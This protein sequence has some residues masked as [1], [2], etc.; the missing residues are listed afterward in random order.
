MKTTQ[1]MLAVAVACLPGC[2]TVD[3]RDDRTHNHRVTMDAEDCA[4]T[5]EAERS[6]DQG[7]VEKKV[8]G[9]GM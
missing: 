5:W 3:N 6:S 7:V 4:I 2:S 9:P 1:I 8:D